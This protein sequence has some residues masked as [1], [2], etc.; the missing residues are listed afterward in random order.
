MFKIVPRD[1]RKNFAEERNENELLF[2]NHFYPTSA[3]LN[4]SQTSET[5]FIVS[6]SSQSSEYSKIKYK[7][8][9][10][11]SSQLSLSY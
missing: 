2:T 7:E 1:H 10:I 6:Y 4:K 3:A 5:P 11:S 9:E 8:N